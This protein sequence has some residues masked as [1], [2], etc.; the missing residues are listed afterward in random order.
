MRNDELARSFIGPGGRGPECDPGSQT[1]KARFGYIARNLRLPPN[2]FTAVRFVLIP[3]MWLCAVSGKPTLLAVLLAAACA[4]DAVDG[5]L[6]RRLRMVTSFGAAFDSLADNLL[7]PSA[8]TWLVLL[9]PTFILDHPVVTAVAIGTYA[10][11]LVVGL[12]RFR[13]FG[14]LHRRSSKWAGAILYLFAMQVL[15]FDT[16]S[17]A[18]FWLSVAMFEYSSLETLIIQVMSR[19]VSTMRPDEGNRA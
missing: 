6:A 4:S 5:E 14:N 11:S 15:L 19:D 12:I 3:V 18:I 2:Q 1:S 9:R 13:R 16:Y 17:L 8:A 7:L 10:A